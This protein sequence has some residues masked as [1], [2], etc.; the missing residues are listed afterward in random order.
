MIFFKRKN[1]TDNVK[2]VYERNEL[3]VTD[4]LDGGRRAVRVLRELADA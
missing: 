3:R 2:T 4:I 1:S